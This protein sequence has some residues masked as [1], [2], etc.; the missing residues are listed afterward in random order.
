MEALLKG[1]RAVS[2]G[3][4]RSQVEGSYCSWRGAMAGGLERS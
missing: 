1:R 2:G 3:V 4:E